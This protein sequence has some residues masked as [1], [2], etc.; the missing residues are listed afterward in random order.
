MSCS[1]FAKVMIFDERVV[2]FLAENCG[3]E[4]NEE[5][6]ARGLQAKTNGT[7]CHAGKHFL[8]HSNATPVVH[9]CG[10]LNLRQGK[11]TSQRMH[12]QEEKRRG[13]AEVLHRQLYQ[14]GQGR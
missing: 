7:W 12:L 8:V 3:C 4:G 6:R 10:F 5:R 13:V 1:P 14:V 2:L 9:T 11:T